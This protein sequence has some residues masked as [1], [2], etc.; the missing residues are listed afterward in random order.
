MTKEQKYG[1]GAS[2]LLCLLLALVLALLALRTRPLQEEEGI[3]VV[4]GAWGEGNSETV[5]AEAAPPPPAPPVSSTPAPASPPVITQSAE[6]T[7]AIEAE[8]QRQ[9]AERQRREA[10][11]RRQ[12]AIRQ[13][14]SNA[15][16]SDQNSNSREAAAGQSSGTS[17]DG[18]TESFNLSGRSLRGGG[19]LRPDYNAQEEGSIVVEITVDPQGN[20]RKAEIRLRGTNI[21]NPDMRRAALAAARQTKFNAI[22]GAQN[23]I[24]TITYRYTLH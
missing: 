18:N 19:L 13:Q 14:M 24:G 6:E 1:F 2:A 4:L 21:E 11:R 20:V 8:R 16:A 23:Q 22:A 5:A 7:A 15:F 12:E 17:A 9:E 3:P 10:E